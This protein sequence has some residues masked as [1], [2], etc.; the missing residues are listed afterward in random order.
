MYEV[1]VKNFTTQILLL[2]TSQ[3]FTDGLKDFL[4]RYKNPTVT[5]RLRYFI[6]KW[7]EEFKDNTS[8]S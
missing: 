1:F 8:L 7:A 4:N 6:K 3:G 2:F 5:R